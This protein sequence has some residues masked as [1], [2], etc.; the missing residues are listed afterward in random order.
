MQLVQNNSC[1]VVSKLPCSSHV[2]KSMRSLHWL[3]VGSR[4]NFKISVII[5]KTMLYDCL[6]LYLHEYFV[7]YL[8]RSI[9]VVLILI[10]RFWKLTMNKVAYSF[11]YAAPR[12]W[13]GLPSELRDSDSLAKFRKGL[14]TYLFALA[15]ILHTFELFTL[16]STADNRLLFGL[17]F[18]IL[19][20]FLAS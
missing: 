10:K 13:N 7:P 1:L 16:W 18:M 14:K 20:V 5:F 2:S 15:Y 3:P 19:V 6:P 11:G 8:V 12:F 4:T 17:C 9:L